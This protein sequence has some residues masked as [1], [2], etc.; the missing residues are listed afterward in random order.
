MKL[1]SR[2]IT[3]QRIREHKFN[4]LVQSKKKK[5]KT[6][7]TLHNFLLLTYYLFMAIKHI[8]QEFVGVKNQT[9]IKLIKH[10]Q[11]ST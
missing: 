2:K 8:A 10:S 11:Q 6:D 3:L 4:W 9:K 5:K 7:E 1:Y